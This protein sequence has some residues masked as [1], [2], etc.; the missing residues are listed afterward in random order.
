MEILQKQTSK[1]GKGRLMFYQE[2]SLANHFHSLDK[3]RERRITATSGQRCYEQSKSA[4]QLGW[5]VKMLLV[6]SQWYSPARRLRWRAK[7]IYSERFTLF[8]NKE[9]STLS[10]RSSRILKA[11]NIPSKHLLYQLVPLEHR[12]GG[13]GYGLLPTP[14]TQGLKVANERGQMYPIAL[15]LLP[16]PTTQEIESDCEVNE[17]GRRIIKSNPKTSHSMNLGRLARKNLLP[18]PTA[19]SAKGNVTKDRG[20]GNL[21]DEIARRYQPEEPQGVGAT[22]L[23]NPLYVEEMMGFPEGWIVSPFLVGEQKL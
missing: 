3:E 2:D 12:T 17:Q 18:T 22:S 4:S 15:D 19:M 6:Y 13:I 7:P 1:H 8:K 20:K 21:T 14:I 11:E 9:K 23:L 10:P 16:T 5:L